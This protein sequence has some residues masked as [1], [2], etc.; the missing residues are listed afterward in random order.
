[1]RSEKLEVRNGGG[2]AENLEAPHFYMKV[3]QVTQG[4]QVAQVLRTCYYPY[5]SF[6]PV[7]FVLNDAVVMKRDV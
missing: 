6:R 2:G 5:P 7:E 1:M 3:S 4:S